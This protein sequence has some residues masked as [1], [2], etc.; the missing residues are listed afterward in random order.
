MPPEASAAVLNVL[1]ATTRPEKR[2]KQTREKQNTHRDKTSEA[3]PQGKNNNAK[4]QNKQ[5]KQ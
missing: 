3:T 4:K 5:A 2:Q 1:H